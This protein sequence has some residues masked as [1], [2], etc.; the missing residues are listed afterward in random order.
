M[1]LNDEGFASWPLHDGALHALS[2]DWRTRECVVTL[3]A[4][5]ISGASATAC[6]IT[7]REVT[8]VRVPNHKPWGTAS[9]TFVNSQR[10]EGNTYI[11]E[12][13]SGDE[14]VVAAQSATLANV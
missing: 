14:V 9:E 7:F 6:A 8:E 1:T 4:F 2:F 3:S 11:L 12:L 13:Q 10:L 5:L